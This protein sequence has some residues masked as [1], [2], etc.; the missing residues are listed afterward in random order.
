[1]A[2]LFFRVNKFMSNFDRKTSLQDNIAR[3][4]F[5]QLHCL[6]CFMIV[7]KEGQINTNFLEAFDF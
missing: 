3:W 4:V 6:S 1:M 5:G 2:D 7:N